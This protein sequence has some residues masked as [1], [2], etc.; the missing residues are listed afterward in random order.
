MTDG[1]RVVLELILVNA[2]RAQTRI[3]THRSNPKG[4]MTGGPR[5][6]HTYAAIARLRGHANFDYITYHRRQHMKKILMSAAGVLLSTCL[7]GSVAAADPVTGDTHMTHSKEMKNNQGVKEGETMQNSPS[8]AS[9]KSKSKET[10]GATHST[11][12]K[13]MKNDQ[14]VK[15]GEPMADAKP[16]P[17]ATEGKQVGDGATHSTHSKQMKNDQ[18]VKEG[19]PMK[20]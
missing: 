11:H 6:R 2:R 19:E 3:I 15:E 9:A 20:D 1:Q 7:I 16:D 12:T 8:S 10:T 13:Q 5:W 14:G 4:L 17:V 18:G